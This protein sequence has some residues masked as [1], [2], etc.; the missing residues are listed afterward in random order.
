MSYM[1]WVDKDDEKD[2]KDS[3]QDSSEHKE[4]ERFDFEIFNNVIAMKE[5]KVCKY[6]LQGSCYNKHHKSNPELH[7]EG[8][9][10][11]KNY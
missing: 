4:K 7:P 9:Q 2:G 6:W 10:G 3:S 11:S 5:R 8:L 1:E